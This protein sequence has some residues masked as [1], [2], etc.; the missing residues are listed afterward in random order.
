VGARQLC[1]Q[2][3]AI[4]PYLGHFVPDP[5][6]RKTKHVIKQNGCDQKVQE[7]SP[8]IAGGGSSVSSAARLPGFM[9]AR[10]YA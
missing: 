1:C 8:G 10:C 9:W 6:S 3:A 5:N 2:S 7:S 4:F